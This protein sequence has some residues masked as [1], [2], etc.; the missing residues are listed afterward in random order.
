MEDGERRQSPFYY[1]ENETILGARLSDVRK[2]QKNLFVQRPSPLD[3]LFDDTVLGKSLFLGIYHMLIAV[4]VIYIVNHCLVLYPLIV[5]VRLAND[6]TFLDT[7]LFYRVR[8]NAWILAFIFVFLASYSFL[9]FF[10]QK[11]VIATDMNLTLARI[12]A[13]SAE[14]SILVYPVWIK[15]NLQYV[16]CLLTYLQVDAYPLRLHCHQHRYLPPQNAFILGYEF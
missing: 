7:E 9:A 4:I 12:I 10:I 5:K 1:G 13:Y 3:D 6:L 14:L 2:G 11:L 15:F 8:E 16:R